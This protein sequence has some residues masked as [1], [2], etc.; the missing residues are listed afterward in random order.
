MY[1][2]S[3]PLAASNEIISDA[4]DPE[5]AAG[6]LREFP[7]KKKKKKQKQC[8]VPVCAHLASG[9]AWNLSREQGYKLLASR[10]RADCL[11]ICNWP[12]CVHAEEKRKYMLFRGVFKDFKRSSVWRS[13]TDGNRNK[14]PIGCAFCSCCETWD[15]Y[16]AF[17][18]RRVFGYHDDGE[19]EVRA[20]VCDNG[21]V[22][23]AWTERPMYT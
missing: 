11:Y 3:E 19:P 8:E 21:H 16:S 15:L 12:G 10:F 17:C 20:Y 5:P 1:V 18:L 13:I 4:E 2:A 9:G 7:R 23:G 22:S 14:I 6:I